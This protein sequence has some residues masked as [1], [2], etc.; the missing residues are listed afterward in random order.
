[1]LYVAYVLFSTGAPKKSEKS[2]SFKKPHIPAIHLPSPLL[3]PFPRFATKK[4]FSKSQFV[5]YLFCSYLFIPK[6]K[7]HL[8]FFPK[9]THQ[10]QLQRE[11]HPQQP[12]KNSKFPQ[13]SM[14]VA[15]K[16]QPLLQESK[17]FQ[18][19]STPQLSRRFWVGKFCCHPNDATSVL[20]IQGFPPRNR[21]KDVT[22]TA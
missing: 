10:H 12:Q 7:K 20:Q 19:A 15:M 11:P 13:K 6:K 22:F 18:A 5:S 2:I 3:S 16:N 17:N 9:K 14:V 21:G 8:R 4:L 1:M